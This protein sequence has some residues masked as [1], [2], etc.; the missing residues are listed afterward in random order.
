MVGKRPKAPGSQSRVAKQ[1]RLSDVSPT[2]RTRGSRRADPPRP[3]SQDV[4]PRDDSTID[5]EIT[6]VWHSPRKGRR[7]N[8]PPP[9]VER[10]R[11][12]ELDTDGDNNTRRNDR[13]LPPP[14]PRT[15]E[16]LIPVDRPSSHVQDISAFRAQQQE[17]FRSVQRHVEEKIMTVRDEVRHEIKDVE[18]KLQ[19]SI[20]KIQT[21][22]ERVAD[23]LVRGPAT[24][25]TTLS[26]STLP[27]PSLVRDDRF[28]CGSPAG[29]PPKK[30]Y[31]QRMDSLIPYFDIAFNRKTVSYALVSSFFE[32]MHSDI[33]NNRVAPNVMKRMLESV[34]MA[35]PSEKG[36]KRR[37][38]S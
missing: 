22:L 5:E 31:A 38:F 36:Q 11:S 12:L 27:V 33:I 1:T 13:S 4:N 14:S 34:L 32:V 15:P 16:A 9:N 30:I 21:T 3:S 23:G 19:D 24:P 28:L 6:S 2:S 35:Q 7:S 8:R 17:H 25:T 37:I 29:A 20:S 18:S 10:E 26:R